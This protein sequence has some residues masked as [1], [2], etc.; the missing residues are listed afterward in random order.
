MNGKRQHTIATLHQQ[1]ILTCHAECCNL[2]AHRQ[3]TSWTKEPTMCCAV[4]NV[5]VKLTQTSTYSSTVLLTLIVAQSTLHLPLRPTF[6]FELCNIRHDHK[7]VDSTSGHASP[8]AF[9]R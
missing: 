4:V 3:L 1:S 7:P 8:S 2:C 9:A 6:C 5:L